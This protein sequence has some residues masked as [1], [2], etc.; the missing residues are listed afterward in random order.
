MPALRRARSASVRCGAD[1][2]SRPA[3]CLYPSPPDASWAWWSAV[4]PVLAMAVA[5]DLGAA[6]MARTRSGLN[7]VLTLKPPCVAWRV[8]DAVAG[9]GG[10][11]GAGWVAVGR[12]RAGLRTE[13]VAWT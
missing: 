4:T 6:T 1:A 3:A 11:L 9:V 7:R 5:A 2:C 10:G 13:R 8:G 12:T